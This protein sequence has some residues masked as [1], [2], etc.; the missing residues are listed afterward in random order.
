MKHHDAFFGVAIT[1]CQSIAGNGRQR[2]GNQSVCW[3][4]THL[5]KMLSFPSVETYMLMEKNN[6]PLKTCITVDAVLGGLTCFA[7]MQ[8]L[9]DTYYELYL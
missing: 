9:D 3:I 1:E 5:K 8:I 4:E 7:K 6:T 2:F